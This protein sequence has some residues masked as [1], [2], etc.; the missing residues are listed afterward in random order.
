MAKAKKQQQQQHQHQ[1]EFKETSINAKR[2][3]IEKMLLAKL[4]TLS[5]KLDSLQF[6][7]VVWLSR[8]EDFFNKYE[9][10]T[11]RQIQTLDAISKKYN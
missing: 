3:S 10:V 9:Y 5:T 7:D 8:I 4:E 2:F 11:E 1:L 6:S